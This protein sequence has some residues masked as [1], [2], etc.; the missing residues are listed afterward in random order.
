M[1]QDYYDT[2]GVQKNA[3]DKDIKSAFRKLAMKYHPDRNKG[4]AAAEK[5]FKQ[6]N[7][8]YAVLSDPQKRKQFDT[9]G[10]AGFNQKFSQEDIFRGADFSNIF[11]EMGFGG[12]GDVFSEIFGGGG[13]R[14]GF[15]GGRGFQQRPTKGQDVEY[16]LT[17]SFDEAYRGGQR[18]I[19]Y[20]LDNGQ[21][22]SLKV[23]IPEG[24][25]TGKKLRVSGRGYPSQYSG[26]KAGDLFILITVGNH[27]QFQR[28]DD[29]IISEESVKLSTMIL[30][31]SHEIKTPDGDKSIKIAAHMKSG[32]KIRIANKGFV[33]PKTKVRGH[34]YAIIKPFI[35]ETITAEQRQ[36]IES[37]Q[38]SG[39]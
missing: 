11:N 37:L 35:P 27:P 18:E 6:I 1:A 13:T 10:A 14:G 39:L 26:G 24:V 32:T 23:K 28:E 2:L 29:H 3:S 19:Q 15:G 7:E 31:G 36:I 25:A 34:F 20:Q 12:G 33:N 9:F 21:R 4:N 17:I 38:E 5:K 8:A 30:G 22:H 16:E